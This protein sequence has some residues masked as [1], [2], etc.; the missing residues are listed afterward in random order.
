[1][2]KPSNMQTRTSNNNLL[3]IREKKRAELKDQPLNAT[4][5]PNKSIDLILKN[6]RKS[7]Q[8][9]L[10]DFG[11][12]EIPAQV[13]RI[14]AQDAV[15]AN[16]SASIDNDENDFKWWDQIDLNKLIAASN[17]IKIIPKDVQHLSTLVTLDVI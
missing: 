11:L 16:K 3:L 15:A 17:K 8:L 1:M 14:N 4:T 7:G 6:A 12:I 2:S 13:W 10:S 9:N 5:M